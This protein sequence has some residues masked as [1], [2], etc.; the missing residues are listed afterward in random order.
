MEGELLRIPLTEQSEPQV[1]YSFSNGHRSLFGEIS[2]TADQRFF[3]F[4][5][6]PHDEAFL[7]DPYGPQ[8]WDILIFGSDSNELLF[9]ERAVL[10]GGRRPC[11]ALRK[12]Q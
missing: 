12:V 7:E 11:I 1:I 2:H 8:P 4:A 10:S 9:S 5:M 6:V 3:G